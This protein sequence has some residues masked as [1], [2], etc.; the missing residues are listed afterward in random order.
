[1]TTT[2]DAQQISALLTS[3]FAPA[4][5]SSDP[6]APPKATID[7]LITFDKKGVSGHPNHV[8]LHRG[9]TAFVASLTRGKAGWQPPV[10]LYT[11]TTVALPRKY[12]AF[13]DAVATLTAWA[14]A[15]PMRAK[16]HPA[17]L[18]FLSGLGPAGWGTAW[19]AMTTAHKSQ[20]VWFRYGWITLSRYMV[21]NDLRLENRVS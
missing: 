16:A 1:M 9:A 18:V 14:I 19:R 6:L 21:I 13:L 3:A 4:A 20:M 10:D 7:V 17:G 12:S 15:T 11:L 2:W 8:S 5:P